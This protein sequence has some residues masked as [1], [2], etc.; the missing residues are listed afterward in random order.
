MENIDYD[1]LI[2][3]GISAVL[4]LIIGLERELKRKPVGLK[5][6]LVISVV[7]CLLTIV[8]IESAYMFPDS[9][10][11]RITMDP[12]RLA[13]QI[14]SGIGFLGAGVILRRGNDSISGLTT[15]AMIWG[16]AGIGIAVG[17]GFFIEAFVG[18]ALLIISVELVPY[19]MKFIGPKQLREKEISLQLFIRDKIQIEN[20]I[21]FLMARKYII[22]RI[23]I[24]DLDNG[25]HL[26]Q[27]LV[28]VDYREKTTDVYDSVSNLDGV[29]KVEIES[30][31]Q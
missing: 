22:R 21:S 20:A 29:Q 13:A 15:A 16:A 23:R 7:S 31:G 28:A 9:D 24:K 11:V 17:A 12:L 14:V 30:M 27:I 6:S 26:V 4:G 19:V 10:H 3:L 2:K 5:T 8:S 1:I 18:V 25:D